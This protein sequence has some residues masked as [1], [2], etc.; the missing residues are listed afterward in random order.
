MHVDS[1]ILVLPLVDLVFENAALLRSS[2]AT[3]ECG[4]AVEVLGNF[5][6]R[7][8]TRLD[9]EDVDEAEFEGE[10]DAL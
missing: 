10:P 8:A 3:N 4:V 5:L 6:E 9:V 7:R 2:V 1:S